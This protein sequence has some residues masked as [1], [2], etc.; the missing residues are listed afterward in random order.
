MTFF[1]TL[2]DQ[3]KTEQAFLLSAP[4]IKDTFAGDITRARYQAFLGQA[5]H[6]VKHTVPL[7]MRAGSLLPNSLEW[8]RKAVVEYIEEEYGH[9]RW[10]L[11]DLKATGA[12]SEQVKNAEPHWSTDAMVSVVYDHM[13][14]YHS[15]AFFG[16][17]HVL[18]GTSVQLA[19]QAAHK[20]QARLALPN[21][22]FSYLLSHGDLDQDHVKF[23][24]DLMNQLTDVEA[25]QAIIRTARSVYHLYGEMFRAIP[26]LAGE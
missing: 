21:S 18:E 2:C 6:H 1:N 16:M 12:D 26:T 8:L 25:Q 13:Q 22:A 10:I 11:N 4:V 19:T 3:T 20:V 7:L 5:Y 9:E 24:E 17:A 15:A 23:F 14:R